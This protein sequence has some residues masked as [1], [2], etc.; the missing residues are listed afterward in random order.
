MFNTYKFTKNLSLRFV[1]IIL[2]SH[3]EIL[4]Q[5]STTIA[6]PKYS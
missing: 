1:I 5:L 2:A 6:H 3:F 4:P